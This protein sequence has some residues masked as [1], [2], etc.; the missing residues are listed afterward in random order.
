MLFAQYDSKVYPL[1]LMQEVIH[2]LADNPNKILLLEEER[3]K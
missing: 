1:D 2:Q 3:K